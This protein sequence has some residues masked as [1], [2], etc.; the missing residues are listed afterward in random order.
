MKLEIKED[1]K[2]ICLIVKHFLRYVMWQAIT[3][4]PVV[5]VP[6]QSAECLVMIDLCISIIDYRLSIPTARR[7]EKRKSKTENGKR[8]IRSIGVR[9]RLRWPWRKCNERLHVLLLFGHRTRNSGLV[10]D[11]FSMKLR[12][13][14]HHNEQ[15][16]Y[17]IRSGH[18]AWN[19][20]HTSRI[21][22]RGRREF[23]NRGAST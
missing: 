11:E 2:V 14:L 15:Q 23:V 16:C 10:L 7:R 20:I 19:R 3:Y 18:V 9:L 22:I 17:T 6:V 8:K 5:P 12:H 13:Y 1:E 4:L 21:R